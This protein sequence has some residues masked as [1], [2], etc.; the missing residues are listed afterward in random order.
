MEVKDHRDKVFQRLQ[1][2]LRDDK[3]RINLRAISQFGIVAMTRQRMRKSVESTS[4]VECPYCA[5]KGVIKS[6]ETIAIEAPRFQTLQW[7]AV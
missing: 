1:D 3:A 7:R 2:K 4:H 6:A 5:G